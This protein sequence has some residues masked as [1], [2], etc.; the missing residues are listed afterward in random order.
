MRDILMRNLIGQTFPHAVRVLLLRVCVVLLFPAALSPTQAAFT[1]YDTQTYDYT[2]LGV[3]KFVNTIYIDL[4][5]ISEISKFRSSF[6]HDYSDSR[7]FGV[8]AYK[9]PAEGNRLEGCSSMKHYFMT[10]D[11]S[12]AIY[13]PTSGVV[14]RMFDESIGGTQVQITSSVQPAF[15]FTMFHVVLTSPLAEGDL[16]TE[17]QLLGHHVGTQTWSDIAVTVHTTRGYHLISYFET[18]TDKAFEAF[19]AK[20]ATAPGDFIFSLGYRKTFPIFYC[21][22]STSPK[23]TEP[24][25]VKLTGGGVTQ[26][27]T[28]KGLTSSFAHVGDAPVTLNATA[29]SGLPVSIATREPKVCHASEGVLSWRRPGICTVMFSQGGNTDTVAAPTQYYTVTVL[30]A[31]ATGLNVPPRLGGIYPPSSSCTQSYLRFHNSGAVAGTVT[32]SLL[33]GDTGDVVAAWTSRS[34]AANSTAQ[35]SIGDLEAAAPQGFTRP[36]IYGLR[37]EPETTLFGYMWHV[38]FNSAVGGL[39]NA[40]SCST[41]VTGNPDVTP[42]VYSSLFSDYL[43]TVVL[44]NPTASS[45]AFGFDTYLT[46]SGAGVGLRGFYPFIERVKDSV[47]PGG[48]YSVA[49]TELETRLHYKPTFADPLFSI[50]ISSVGYLSGYAQHIFTST[51]AN[52]IA[53]MTQGCSLYGSTSQT[54]ASPLFTSSVLSASPVS[55]QSYFRFYNAGS[56]T[57]TATVALRDSDTG[58]ALGRWTTPSIPPGAQV[59]YPVSIIE[60]EAGFTKKSSYTATVDTVIDGY[61]QHILFRGPNGALSNLSTCTGATTIDSALLIGVHSS[62]VGVI[63]FP[64]TIV[65]NNTGNTA[66]AAVLDIIDARDGHLLETFTTPVIPS[67]A[68]GRFDVAAIENAVNFQPGEGLGHYN[69]KLRGGFAGYLQHFIDNREAGVVT[70][71]TTMCAM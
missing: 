54:V 28:H 29:T 71:L 30:P 13:A 64:S 21:A 41:G 65:V 3:P 11:D 6:G 23:S 5:K 9:D 19:K 49:V 2:T 51:R 56:V 66:A 24:E 69:I 58:A 63:G 59:Q 57:G 47:S 48:Q 43:S 68:Q 40:S 32:A 33:N 35:F 27:I 18:L 15:T 1:Q 10:P 26:A 14:S 53:D 12:V 39:T 31:G 67:N 7:Q 17:G 55:G 4:T 36:S 61:F 37:I 20:G 52:V 60:N 42:F 38:L 70:D 50:G 16:V 46:T 34:I 45:A 62:L 44:A 8:D 22:T 25:S